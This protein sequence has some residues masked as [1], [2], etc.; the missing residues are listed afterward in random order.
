MQLRTQA[1][2]RTFVV[3]WIGQL[4]SI[5]GSGLTDFALGLYVYQRTGSVTQFAFVLLFRALPVIV[6]SPF[7][8]ALVDRWDKRMVMLCSDLVAAFSSLILAILFFSNQLQV[9]HIYLGAMVSAAVTAFQVPAY[10]T[11]TTA[12]IPQKHLGRASGMVQI[13]QACAEI[14][15]P[16]LAGLLVVVIHLQGVL[17]LDVASFGFSVLTLLAVRFPA[18]TSPARIERR[19]SLLT[20]EIRD[21]VVY[22]LLRPGLVALLVFFAAVYFEG[23]MI[24]AL[25]QPLILAFASPDVLGL[26]LAVAGS[27]LLLG[28]LL[29]S[30]WGGP[31][32]RIN[33][34][35]GF[36]FLFGVGI[37]L[38]GLRP[39]PTLVGIG[40]FGAHFCFPFVNG[41]N[42][43]IWQSKV[44]FS[45]QGRVFAIRQMVVRAAQVLAFVMVGPLTD[46]IFTP[47]L[48][49]SGP[50]AGTVG[51]AIGVGA[52]RG[53]ALIFVVMGLFS[54]LTAVMGWL[55]PQLRHVEAELP[56]GLPPAARDGSSV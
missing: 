36:V 52:G 11:A 35:L 41:C 42:Q 54:M 7:A 13:A 50:L 21:G 46:R 4:V 26:I 18:A 23:A 37:I 49:E 39:S 14:S 16:L 24:S 44:A 10:L 47:L 15:A 27:G 34:V 9:W 48:L 55:Y 32:R 43:A 28:G 38:I 40:A 3:V 53:I 12:L 20:R 22:I 56:A 2:F 17:L 51:K 45:L 8:G 30:A 1:G 6:I 25:V 19:N 33:G 29:L 31:A 5:I